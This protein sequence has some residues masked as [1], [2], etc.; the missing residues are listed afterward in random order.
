MSRDESTAITTGYLLPET[1]FHKIQA[2]NSQLQLMRELAQRPDKE[3]I[4]ITARALEETLALIEQALN[5]AIE[6]AQFLSH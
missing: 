1:A 3:A 5:D 4:T 2:L 6:Q